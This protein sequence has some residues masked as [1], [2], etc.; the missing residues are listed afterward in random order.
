MKQE[1]TNV[2][3]GGCDRVEVAVTG[4]LSVVKRA[5]AVKK[6]ART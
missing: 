3:E 4:G 1:L 2:L 5:R 6:A